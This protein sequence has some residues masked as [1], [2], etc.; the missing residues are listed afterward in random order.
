MHMYT[1]MHIWADPGTVQNLSKM[2]LDLPLQLMKGQTYSWKVLDPVKLLQ[3]YCL[4]CPKYRS[5]MEY[6][7]RTYPNKRAWTLLLY[8]DEVTP[9]NVFLGRRKVHVWYYTFEEF[10]LHIRCTD[11]WLCFA[12]LQST[13]AQK[14]TGG[15]SKVSKLVCKA[16][17]P[18][19]TGVPVQLDEAYMVFAELDDL[20]D[21]DAL[22]AKWSI[23][24]HNGVKPCMHCNVCFMKGHPLVGRDPRFVDITDLKWSNVKDHQAK[25]AE[26]W[27]AQDELLQVQRGKKKLETLYGMNTEPEGL[28]AAVELRHWVKPSAS[29][30][31]P[32]HVYF[33]KGIAE[34][35]ISLLCS[36]LGEMYDFDLVNSFVNSGWVWQE[37][38]K[39]RLHSGGVKGMAS[40]VLTTVTMLRHFLNKVVAPAL[41]AERA[42][43]EA[44]ANVV[45]QMQK[46]K[47]TI[48]VPDEEADELDR[49][50]DLHFTA[51]KEAYGT[52]PI[53]PKHHQ[54]IHLGPQAKKRKLWVD[55]YPCERKHMEPKEVVE[56]YDRAKVI[57]HVELTLVSRLNVLQLQDMSGGT[58]AAH[59]QEPVLQL[60]V[61]A[62]LYTP[63]APSPYICVI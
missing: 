24:G 53:V 1:H 26:L 29:T 7:I 4:H 36:K 28:L 42:S 23:K 27:A 30:Y 5:L 45:E 16:L 60:Q 2:H 48:N 56:C 20:Q 32:M 62:P 51:F 47:R 59:L 3:H 11:S 63:S 8:E 9:G 43:F 39:L 15:F 17:L 35:E 61:G 41:P 14:A 19:C 6:A 54:A 50:Q 46:M 44:L 25:D 18:F 57:K 34:I 10:D 22:R 40:E 21:A 38:M 58:I 49:L 31:D 12:M 37:R 55:A 52:D 13:I 33:S